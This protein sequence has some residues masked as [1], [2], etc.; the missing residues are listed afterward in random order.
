MAKIMTGYISGRGHA[1][2]VSVAITLALV[3]NVAANF[4]LIP[5]YGIVGA[6][7]ASVI[8]YTAH[9]SIT[10]VM[11]SRL[12]GQPMRS[13]LIPGR[14]EAVLFVT[15]L[16]RLTDRLP[17]FGRSRSNEGDAR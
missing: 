13:L 16:W 7:L 8:S 6:S 15:G 4:I 5:R 17:L 10:L 14:T 11:A 12:S 3:L 9:A 2:L 1:G